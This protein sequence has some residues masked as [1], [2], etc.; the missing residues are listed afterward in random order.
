LLNFLK[1]FGEKECKTDG[2]RNDRTNSFCKMKLIGK[3]I[4]DC[5]TLP[6]NRILKL[7]KGP[8]WRDGY[9]DAFILPI[10][11]NAIPLNLEPVKSSQNIR[12]WKAATDSAPV[13]IKFFNSRGLKDRLPFKKTRACRALEGGIILLQND[14]LTPSV[15]AYGLVLRGLKVLENFMITRWIEGG[16]D[17][18]CYLKTFFDPPVSG[19]VLKKK[20]NFIEALGRLIGRM[21]RKGIYHGDLRPGNILIENLNEDFHFYF[22]D[23]EK[24]EY[25]SQGIPYRLREKNLI[26]LNMLVK[27]QITFTDRLRFFRAYLLENPAMASAGKDVMLNVM[28]KTKKRLSKTHPGSWEKP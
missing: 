5:I 7:K 28:K 10:L 9:V 19:D 16:Q 6:S 15:I 13:F 3:K 21:H 8:E 18:Y 22:I 20:R 17:T 11:N 1:Y 25:F 2:R 26:Q 27:P 23:N 12:C 24:T 14:F 4:N